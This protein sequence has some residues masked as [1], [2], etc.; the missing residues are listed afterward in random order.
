MVRSKQVHFFTIYVAAFVILLNFPQWNLP[1][2]ALNIVAVCGHVHVKKYW[3]TLMWAF[4]DYPGICLQCACNCK[5]LGSHL[6]HCLVTRILQ[7]VGCCFW[8]SK[9]P[10]VVS[11][12]G[13]FGIK[14]SHVNWW[15]SVE[16]VTCMWLVS[17][18][19]EGHILYIICLTF[20]VSSC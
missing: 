19:L 2:F 3:K 10:T 11:V 12:T 8:L 15:L 20:T 7:V 6:K 4:A 13:Q 5:T 9:P 14:H 16:V 1:K 17:G 18:I